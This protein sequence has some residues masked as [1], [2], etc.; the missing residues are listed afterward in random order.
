MKSLG[1]L[2]TCF[3]LINAP[4]K[5]AASLDPI[6]KELMQDSSFASHEFL[7]NKD[8]ALHKEYSALLL[9]E[10]PENDLIFYVFN[11]TG[12]DIL[13]PDDCRISLAYNS[14]DYN[15]HSLSFLG[16]TEDK[17]FYKFKVDEF[18]INPLDDKREYKIG[19]FEVKQERIY[20][21]GKAIAVRETKNYLSSSISQSYT[22]TKDGYTCNNLTT[23]TLDVNVG[24]K[25]TDG[26][27]SDSEVGWQKW[28][29]INY[30][31]FNTPKNL[32]NLIGLKLD[33]YKTTRIEHYVTHSIPFT[34]TIGGV[35]QPDG[36]VPESKDEMT[37]SDGNVVKKGSLY[38]VL[39]I[40]SVEYKDGNNDKY[41]CVEYTDQDKHSII[42]SN[43]FNTFL[44]SFLNFNWIWSSEDLKDLKIIEPIDYS[45][46][47]KDVINKTNTYH[48]STEDLNKLANEAIDNLL[49]Q[50]YLIRFDFS[51]FGL[52]GSSK[53]YGINYTYAYGLGN[54]INYYKE[55]S[56]YRDIDVITLTY[57]KDGK[58]YTLPVV[59][60]TNELIPG[61]E[62][63]QGQMP[64]LLSLLLKLL[65]ALFVIIILIPFLPYV[66]QLI[67]WIIT[68]P[69]KLIKRFINLFK[70][71]NKKKK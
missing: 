36:S 55:K 29:D 37:L 38:N 35:I 61:D 65:L 12:F 45:I 1:I 57:S 14:D 15:H 25:R 13:N 48:L 27:T 8:V 28:T 34:G 9:Y 62:T 59:S 43:S 53:D 49:N 20:E 63:P 56:I 41:Y 6:Y 64:D 21:N 22:Y 71:D 2:L 50:T 66:I 31:Y 18:V 68:L 60:N 24:Y 47:A 10:H 39:E 32:G 52:K 44:G 51:N 33:F 69:F 17:K 5:F 16:N 40:D 42:G 67:V 3:S 46:I 7:F 54:N 30:I 4:I 19:E 26:L 23:I 58:E 70:K 11:V